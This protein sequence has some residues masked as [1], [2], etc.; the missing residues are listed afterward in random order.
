M[1]LVA[2]VRA[3]RAVAVLGRR[4]GGRAERATR[5]APADAPALYR[6]LERALARLGVRRP[7][8][9]TLEEL[10][11]RID[12]EQPERRPAADLVRRYS[13]FRYG[14]LGDPGALAAD[15]ARLDRGR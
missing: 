12:R 4:R 6:A 11:E 3:R 10:A 14:G 1:G 9:E 7:P 8:H 5:A 15:I 2:F 13:A